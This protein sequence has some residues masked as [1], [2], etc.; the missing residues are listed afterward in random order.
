MYK[1]GVSR[2]GGER[3]RAD[4]C[5]S[6][7]LIFRTIFLLGLI[8]LWRYTREQTMYSKR[9]THCVPYPV[10]VCVCTYSAQSHH[11]ILKNKH[12]MIN[13]P[14]IHSIYSKLVQGIC[15]YTDP[16]CVFMCVCLDTNGETV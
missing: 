15:L 12:N 5:C 14:Y 16:V 11:A 2:V 3:E 8:L 4:K 9:E 10:C 6:V 1:R 13:P 7:G